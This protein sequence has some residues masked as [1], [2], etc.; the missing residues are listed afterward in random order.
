MFL[1]DTQFQKPSGVIE[2]LCLMFSRAASPL[3]DNQPSLLQNT[4]PIRYTSGVIGNL[5][6]FTQHSAL[7]T[8]HFPISPCRS[9]SPSTAAA[10][11]PAAASTPVCCAKS[12]FF[13]LLPQLSSPPLHDGA[14]Y[15]RIFSAKPSP[16]QQSAAFTALWQHF[17]SFAAAAHPTP[18]TNSR[19]SRRTP[20]LALHSA[21]CTF[22]LYSALSTFFP[23]I[24]PAPPLQQKGTS[25][26]ISNFLLLS[27]WNAALS[28]ILL[29]S[30][31]RISEG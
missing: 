12:A 29:I 20:F 7:R 26:P 19:L 13:T 18:A 1:S 14:Q 11:P 27:L 4:P 30:K 22:C 6:S 10:P 15:P 8:Q 2:Y 23:A 21:L 28:I 25:F 9:N 24:L 31:P 5:L 16:P 3:S 17:P